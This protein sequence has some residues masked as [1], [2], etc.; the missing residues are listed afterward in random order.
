MAEAFKAWRHPTCG[1]VQDDSEGDP[2]DG[3]APGP[4]WGDLPPEWIHPLC[5][6]PKSDFD[7][8][9]V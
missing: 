3:L 5:A 7:K 9:N 8:V 6:T 4:R 1:Y 2:A